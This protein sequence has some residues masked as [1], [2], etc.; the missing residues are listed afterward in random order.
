VTERWT[1][2]HVP[3]VRAGEHVCVLYTLAQERDGALVPFLR[4]G[5]SG[6]DKCVAALT[7]P[8]PVVGHLGSKDAVDRWLASGQLEAY[9]S[10]DA[11]GSAEALS[12]E[13][14]VGFWER[15]VHSAVTTQGFGFVRLVVEVDWALRRLPGAGELMRYEATLN[16]LS[17]RYP[18]AILCLCDVSP[19]DGG[20]IIDLVR[21]HPSLL[22]S[23]VSLDNPY[24]LGPESFPAGPPAG[25]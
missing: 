17:G 11:A 24:Y 18:V 8:D 3:G 2:A 4:A 14:L 7:D 23:N 22:F 12:I 20:L 19:L 13:H 10:A 15:V 9:G 6:T 16:S 5:L 1:T 21:T 25:Y